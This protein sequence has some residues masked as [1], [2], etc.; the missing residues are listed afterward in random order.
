MSWSCSPTT[1]PR[2]VTP[3]G[4]PPGGQP[5]PPPAP[6]RAREPARRLREHA[7]RL[8]AGDVP[9]RPHHA[10]QVTAEDARA[11][12]DLQHVP[13]R[14]DAGEAQEPPAEPGPT[15]GPAAGPPGPRGKF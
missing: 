15:R 1:P 3:P 2:P 6:P 7:A 12:A 4:P 11:A 14:T 8:H 9:A 5:A 10:G 13:P